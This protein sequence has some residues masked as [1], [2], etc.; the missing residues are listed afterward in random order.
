MEG[1][2][3]LSDIQTYLATFNP[4]DQPQIILQQP[5][6]TFIKG[7]DQNQIDDAESLEDQGLSDQPLL[8]PAAPAIIDDQQLVQGQHIISP[9]EQG[10]ILVSQAGQGS[11][12]DNAV[13]VCNFLHNRF[14]RMTMGCSFDKQIYGI[15]IATVKAVLCNF[16]Y[17]YRC[18]QML[19]QLASHNYLV[20][21][22]W[23][24]CSHRTVHS[25]W[26]P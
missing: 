10:S 9:S 14:E 8:T 21:S 19:L 23:W 17:L 16:F 2:S 5:D 7:E 18:W 20:S 26:C 15:G 1:Q 4:K 13:Q 25:R 11:G 6:G 22:R 24:L 12:T 3:Q